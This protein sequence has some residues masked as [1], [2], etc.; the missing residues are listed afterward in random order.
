MSGGGEVGGGG[1]ILS[2]LHLGEEASIPLT[3]ALQSSLSGYHGHSSTQPRA[4]WERK[5]TSQNESGGGGVGGST[6][7]CVNTWWPPSF[8]LEY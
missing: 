7:I 3:N 1:D 6:V 4:N 8:L 2:S 5:E